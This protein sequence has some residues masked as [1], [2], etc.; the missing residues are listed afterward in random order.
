MLFIPTEQLCAGMV[1]AKDIYLHVSNAFMPPLLTKG[2]PLT[3]L[4]LRK[5]HMYGIS[6]AYVEN[7]LLPDEI[8]PEEPLTEELK[9]KSLHDIRQAFT[10]FRKRQYVLEATQMKKLTNLTDRLVREMLE[11]PCGCVNDMVDLHSYD[12]YTYHHSLYVS[13]LSIATGVSLG[14]PESSLRELALAALLHDIGKL[15]V[16][17]EII[18]KPGML[19]EAEFD[20]V[21]Q[22]PQQGVKYLAGRREISA[23]I[24]SGIEFHHERYNGSG[25]PYGLAGEKIPYYARI[26]AVCDVYNALTSTRPYKQRSFPS[27]AVEYM[28]GSAQIH[29]DYDILV[30]FLK[31]I[32][33]YPVGI[34]VK[35][36]NGEQAVVIKNHPGSLLRPTIRILPPETG[37]TGPLIHLANDARYASVT[38]VDRGYREYR[39]GFLAAAKG[40]KS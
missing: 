20:L 29:F 2:Q 9:R 37:A 10:D 16:P 24:L 23:A 21:K 40:A 3:E 25:Y 39:T 31:N 11:S 19:T 18:N 6:G 8:E 26:L 22:H 4:Y 32:A 35:L 34:I 13:V 12:D 17:V 14:L 30:A 7:I 38:I 36:S 5:L 27:E 28:L 15:A 1:L 33:A